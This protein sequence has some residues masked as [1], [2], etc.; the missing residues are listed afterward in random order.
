VTP[1]SGPF[2][3]EP[4]WNSWQRQEMH[5]GLLLYDQL[6]ELQRLNRHANMALACAVVSLG[7][8]IVTLIIALLIT[9][10]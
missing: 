2:D 7:M 9:W 6:D 10:H 5:R 8:S 4:D 1:V 3:A